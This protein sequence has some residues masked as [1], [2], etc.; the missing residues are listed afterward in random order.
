MISKNQLNFCPIC[1]KYVEIKR[2]P[3]KDYVFLIWAIVIIV[4][5]GLA[6]PV[7]IYLYF[8]RKK[9]RC[10]KCNNIVVIIP[11]GQDLTKTL[12]LPKEM[13]SVPTEETH[14]SPVE[15]EMETTEK[16]IEPKQA[17]ENPQIKNAVIFYRRI[18]FC[19]FCG[20]KIS[21]EG[22]ELCSSCGADLNEGD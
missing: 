18:A 6:T 17:Q 20:S 12:E 19:P 5:L 21:D 15:S 16:I 1:K 4:S 11:S 13:Y 2:K 22:Q 14:K 3:F 7:L 10:K 9:N 8:R